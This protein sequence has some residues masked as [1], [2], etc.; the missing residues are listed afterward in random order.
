M[1]AIAVAVALAAAVLAAPAAASQLSALRQVFA[2]ELNAG[3]G[4]NGA[5]VVDVNTGQTLYAYNA[6]VGRKPAS[7]EKIYTTSTALLRFGPSATLQTTVY[8]VGTLRSGGTFDGSL[9]LHGGGDPSFGSDSYDNYIYGRGVIHAT[10][11]SLVAQLAQ[12]GIKSVKGAVYGDASFLDS[13]QG[14]APYGFKVSFDLGSPL[15]A[16]LYNRGWSDLTGY[17]FQ[18]SPPLYAAQELVLAL[19]AAHVKVPGNRVSTGTTPAAAQ[20][21]ASVSSPTMAR[22]IALTNTPSDNLFAETLIKD[23]GARFGAR[24]STAAGA[25]VVRAEVASQFGIH[26]KIYDG[27]GLSYSDSSSPSDIVTALEKMA[28]NKDFVNSLAIAGET[29]TLQ[30]EMVGTNAQGQCRAKTGTLAADSAL[31]G[32]CR[33]RDGHTLV[34]SILQNYVSPYTEHPLQNLMAEA[35]VRY[36]G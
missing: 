14:T 22:L 24:G 10:M 35:L 2:Q 7:N 19:R 4:S 34:F 33:A 11:Q 15:S 5:M 26:P 25:T 31:S 20:P 28:A 23:L 29:G 36:N 17:H 16:L 18:A 13:A 12:L 27:S 6:Y 30:H 32:Y 3:G 9:Y 8:G 21:L 1:R